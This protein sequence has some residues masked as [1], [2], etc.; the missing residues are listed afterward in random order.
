MRLPNTPLHRKSDYV[1]LNLMIY[2]SLMLRLSYFMILMKDVSSS[3]DSA[4]LRVYQRSGVLCRTFL[5]LHDQVGV[6]ALY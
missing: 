6:K 5:L 2:D 4:F 3:L 1:Q